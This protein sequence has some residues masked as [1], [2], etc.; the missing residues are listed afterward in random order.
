MGL[1]PVIG[2][3]K[4]KRLAVG[5]A[6]LGNRSPFLQQQQ[7]QQKFAEEPPNPGHPEFQAWLLG[8]SHA[9][10]PESRH[11]DTARERHRRA[12]GGDSEAARDEALKV[13]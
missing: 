2:C 3:R 5:Q 11:R 8:C 7:Q 6:P 13:E 9:Q 4:A 1:G 10:G 12:G